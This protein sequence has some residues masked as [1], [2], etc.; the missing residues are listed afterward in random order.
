MKKHPSFTT[1]T[2]LCWRVFLLVT[3]FLAFQ[4]IPPAL[5]QGEEAKPRPT[6]NLAAAGRQ[7]GPP[8]SLV[9]A[10]RNNVPNFTALSPL[11]IPPS[12]SWAQGTPYPTTIVRYGFVQTASH[13][14]VFGG[15]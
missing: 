10:S 7:A 1:M 2:S 3:L 15:V 11:A 8:A 14:Y 5:G 4:V 12:T 9:G 13:F 6:I